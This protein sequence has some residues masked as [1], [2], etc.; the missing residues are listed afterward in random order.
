MNRRE[1]LQLGIAAC[2]ASAGTT[3]AGSGPL[4]G[5]I[6]KAVTFSMI[7]DK[8]S[9]L[10]KFKLLKDVGYDGVEMHAAQKVD[11]REV[12]RAIEAAALPV[13][14]VMNSSSPNIRAS[15]DL[16]RFYGG[17]SVLIVAAED[18]QRT[19]DE[20]FHHWQQLI[21][22][23]VPHAE[24]HQIRLLV[25][26]VRL[27]FLK[28]AEG[29]ARFVDQ[30]D[31]PVVGAYFDAGNAITWTK[32]PAEHWARVLGKRIGKLHIKDRGH[33]EFGDPKLKSKTAIGTDGGEVHWENVRNELVRVN[34]SG[35][36]TAEI[37]G[38]GDRKRLAGIAKWMDQVLG[39]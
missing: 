31:S 36:A 13:H 2:A 20:N 6:K 5:K 8:L 26:N 34:F 7:R 12:A 15:I 3:A 18:P 1:L 21:R 14:G 27:T 17:T 4:A 29:M 32:Q 38:G 39:L 22:A 35:W 30:C 9:V 23:A 33:A 11:R 24:K 10:D 25:E 28:S 37:R 16:A 19:Y